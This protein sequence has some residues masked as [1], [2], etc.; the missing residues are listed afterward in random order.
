MEVLSFRDPA[1]LQR[2][3]MRSG[4]CR[5]LVELLAEE[6]VAA[7]AVLEGTGLSAEDL[8]DRE[9]RVSYADA[10]R[11]Y[12]N[13]LDHSREPGLGL[14]LGLR[15]RVSDHG[16]FGYA[17]QSSA[18]LAQATRIAIRFLAATGPLLDLS[19][20]TE[21]DVASLVLREVLPLGP[22]GRMAREEHVVVVIQNLLGLTEPA[23]VPLE[24]HLDL[25]PRDEELCRQHFGCPVRFGRERTEIRLRAD[26]L[27]QPLSFADEE[28]AAVC[29]RRVRE[30]LE[31]LG[32]EGGLVERLRRVLVES[33][34]RFPS[35]AQ[36]ARTLG[37]SDRTLRRRLQEADASYQGVL[38]DVRKG[39][40]LDYLQRSNLTV[41]EI[42]E[43]L[44][45][46]E[47]SN[48]YRA[49]KKWT[50]EPPGA[51][52]RPGMG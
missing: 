45:Y 29:E 22:I 15:Q 5:H 33:P 1:A 26:D 40:A 41:D 19:L 28:T 44:G 3:L 34:G 52:R 14:R 6:G 23:T 4:Y 11:I 37:M 48:F 36:A 16:I 20:E 38:E 8:A 18:D 17:I 43:L 2:P 13:A 25:P 47:T 7:D 46:A 30:L 50:G 27:A 12:A 49:F 31:R 39:L 35:L 21:G 10:L 9:R 32:S 24:V 51:Y 42:A